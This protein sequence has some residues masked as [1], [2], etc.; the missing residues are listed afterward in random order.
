VGEHERETRHELLALLR[1]GR[2]ALA[3]AK[4][5]REHVPLLGAPVQA[6]ERGERLLVARIV[7]GARAPRGD[8]ARWIVERGL[9]DLAEAAPDAAARVAVV[10]ELDLHAEHARELARLVFRGV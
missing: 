3:R 7:L 5:G 10:L 6:I 4:H 8:G 1:I 2:R 9:V